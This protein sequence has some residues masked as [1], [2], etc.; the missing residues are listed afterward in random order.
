MTYDILLQNGSNDG[1]IATV[2]AFPGCVVRASTRQEAIEGVQKAIA[3]YLTT[4]EILQVEVPDPK[5]DVRSNYA[6]TFGM[7]RDDPTYHEFLKEVQNFRQTHDAPLE[8]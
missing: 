2:L 1:Y 3:R 4:G 5:P 7:F 6:N 8:K